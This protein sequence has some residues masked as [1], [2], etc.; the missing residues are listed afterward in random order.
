MKFTFD[1][2]YPL[3]RKPCNK[4]RGEYFSK[5]VFMRLPSCIL[6][7]LASS[8]LYASLL[9]SRYATANDYTTVIL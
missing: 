1:L 7:L 2:Q 3:T 9:L 4:V 8:F 5:E 6:I